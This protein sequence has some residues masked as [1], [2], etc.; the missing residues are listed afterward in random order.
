MLK[1]YQSNSTI[2]LKEGE[3]KMKYQ[4]SYKSLSVKVFTLIELLVVIAIIAILAG[5]LLPALNKARGKA[6][7]ISC[8]NNQ[9]QI[10]TAMTMYSGDYDGIATPP[11]T[12]AGAATTY[13]P[14]RLDDYMG[15]K[16]FVVVNSSDLAKRQAVWNCPS[17][18]L[19]NQGIY[20]G[21]GSTYMLNQNMNHEGKFHWHG[22]TKHDGALKLNHIK[23]PTRTIRVAPSGIKDAALHIVIAERS[24]FGYGSYD[25]NKSMGFWH[26]S[27]GQNS[28]KGRAPT[29]YVDGHV[30]AITMEEAKLEPEGK[31][32]SFWGGF[33]IKN[34]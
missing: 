14:A 33:Y 13:W 3:Q 21:Y 22:N 28:Y 1:Y 20:N 11:H 27:G 12:L 25:P 5:M 29:Q 4:K 23:W 19:Y 8:V 24:A 7:E 6:K 34:H 26:G 9:K 10:G 32:K 31:S 18:F 2:T 17:S 16:K 15:S 30:K